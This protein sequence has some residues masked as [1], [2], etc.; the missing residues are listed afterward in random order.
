MNKSVFINMATKDVAAARDFYSKLGFK[1]NEEYSNDQNVFVV[2]NDNVQLILAD[3]V[4]FQQNQQREIAD[5]TKVAE[6]GIAIEVSSREEVDKIVNVAVAA[7]GK[8]AG[9]TIE[10]AEIGMYSRGLTDLGGHRLDI[11]TMAS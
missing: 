4:F 2:V 6:V 5:T 3:T 8:L 7:G 1:V 11:L 9:E 10:E